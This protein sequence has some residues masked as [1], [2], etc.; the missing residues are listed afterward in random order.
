MSNNACSR[1][2][3]FTTRYHVQSI[4]NLKSRHNATS[5]MHRDLAAGEKTELASL[6]GL[7]CQRR[8]K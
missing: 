1:E 2:F 6:T 5:S 3:E 8:I 7:C 4:Q